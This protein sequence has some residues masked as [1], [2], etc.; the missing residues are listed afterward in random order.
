MNHSK[1]PIATLQN[2]RFSLAP[3]A[4]AHTVVKGVKVELDGHYRMFVNSPRSGSRLAAEFHNIILDQGLDRFWG[5]QLFTACQVGTGTIAPLATQTGLASFSAGTSTNMSTTATHVPGAT[6]YTELVVRYRFNAGVAVGTFSEVGVGWSVSGLNNL[7]SRAL[8][9]DSGGVPTT[10][11]VLSDESLDVEYRLRIYVP[12]ADTTGTLT[13]SGTPYPWTAR[14]A[15][16]ASWSINHASGGTVMVSIGGYGPG[17]VLGPITGLPTGGTSGSASPSVTHPA[18]VV[19]SYTLLVNCTL[20]LTSGNIPGGIQAM[21]ITFS[22]CLT[23]QMQFRFSTVI[24]KDAT[25]VM[26]FQL[27]ITW[28]RRP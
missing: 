13:L 19:G 1:S 18:Y 24:P 6:P 7:F 14:A 16:S 15:S 8:I 26:T 5:S 20:G 10:V 27:R 9:L 25:K 17:A 23:F 3:L 11:T 2:G 22:G 12:I 4:R 28:A 21:Y